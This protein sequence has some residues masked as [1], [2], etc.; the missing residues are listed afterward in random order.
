M[1]KDGWIAV[2]GPTKTLS[3]FLEISIIPKIDTRFY[4]YK[5]CRE[6]P[7]RWYYSLKDVS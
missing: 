3:T 2:S 4:R 1:S 5:I 7:A 6:I